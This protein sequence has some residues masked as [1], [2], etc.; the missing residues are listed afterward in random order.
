MWNELTDEQMGMVLRLIHLCSAKQLVRIEE[1]CNL[2]KLFLGDWDA[3]DLDDALDI[4]K[5]E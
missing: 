4:D 1:Q 5:M 3:L 2:H